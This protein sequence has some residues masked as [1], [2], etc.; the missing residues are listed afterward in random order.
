MK[1]ILLL[2]L[3]LIASANVWAADFITDV[4]VIGGSKSVVND[5]KDTY[6][7]QGW[8]VIDQDLNKGCGSSSDYIYLL[9]KKASNVSLDAGAFITGFYISDASGT[10][11]DN[12]TH[13][14]H[15]YTLVPY[16]GSDYFMGTKGDLNSHCGANSAYIHLYY[17]KDNDE[18]Y[19]STAV[20]AI[21]FND[22]QSGA[23]GV[24][25]GTTGYDLNTGGGGDYIYMHT[26]AGTKGWT[27]SMN[28]AQT[29]CSITGY[30]GT[31]TNKTAITIP[32]YIDGAQV[33]GFTGTVFSGWT[34][35]ETMVFYANTQVSQM[36]S[37][38][39]CSK[40][41]NIKTG[42]VNYKTPSSMTS[43]PASAFVGTAIT[44]VTLTSVTSVG[45]NAFAGSTTLN[46]VVFSK[47]GVT[48]GDGAFS[49][50]VRSGN[51]KCQVTY[52]GVI[53]D[54]SPSKYMYSPSLVVNG[55]SGSSAWSCGWC[56]GGSSS[57][58]NRLYWTL[59]A[60]GQLKIDCADNSWS[61]HPSDQIIIT[62][63][64]DK[65]KVKNLTIEHVYSIAQ[66]EFQSCTNLVT[67]D[68]KSGVTNIGNFAFNSCT[69]LE[70]AYLPSCLTSIGEYAFRS[71]EL[72]T[73]LFFNGTQQQWGN[74][75]KGTGWNNYVSD[76]FTEHWRCTV[77]F[78]ANGHGTAP[79]AQTL[80][81]NYDKATTPTAPTANGC[82]FQGWYTE[83][84]CTNQ[85][86]FNTVV[87]GDMTL[88]A[89]WAMRYTYNS[90]TGELALLWGE[91]N[92]DNKWG[93][94][95]PAEA[96]TSV[97]ATS[98][99][100]FTGDCSQLFS[101][102][103]NCTSMDLDSVNTSNVTNMISMFS[104]CSS[105]TSLNISS[106]NTGNVT[107]MSL[108]FS[109][110]SSLT[111][112]N[113]S[114]WNTSNVT[115]M[116][117]MFRTCSKLTSLDITGWDTGNVE[118]MSYMFNYCTSL[119]SLNLSGWNITRVNFMD[120]MFQDCT[121]LTS[122]DL[123]G[124]NIHSVSN[125]TGMFSLCSSLKS[126]NLSGWVI[127]RWGISYM[128]KDCNQLTTIYTTTSW[129]TGNVD[130][131]SGMFSGCTKLVGGMGTTY[132]ENHT[133]KE[134]ARI[135]RGAEQPGYFTGVFKLI[136]P[137][138]VTTSA[139]P[140][141]TIGDSIYYAAGTAVILTYTGNV[142]EGKVV[143]FAV[144]G[145]AIDGNTFEMPLNDVT[146][147]ATVT[148]PP[149]YTYD[150]ATG[151]LTLL[152]GEFNKDNKWGN[153]VPAT[154]VKSVT[155]TSKVSFTGDC[156]QLFYNFESCESM[157]L[158]HVNTSAMTSTC[159]MFMQCEALTTLNISSWNTGNVTNMG[160]MFYYCSSMKSFDISGW[161]TASVT[162]MESMFSYCDSLTSL[163][164]SSWNTSAV[165]NMEE[166]F[167]YCSSMKSFDIS[168]WNTASVTSMSGM[169]SFCDSLTSLNLSGWNM[170]NVTNLSEMF[171][172]CSSM[173]SINISGW[174]TTN[175][176]NMS[177]MFVRCTGLT[178]LDLSGWDTGNVTNMYEMFRACSNLTTI[179]VGAD[180]STE[181]VTTSGFMFDG[182]TSLVGGMGTTYDMY[183]TNKEYAHID[184]GSANPGYLS[185]KTPRYTYDSTTGVLSLNWGT[186]NK[187]DK[188]GSEVI[189]TDVTSVTATSD[190][191]FTGDCS[192]LFKGFSNCTSM[193]LNHVNTS[194]VI[195]IS[196]MFEN[197]SSLTLLD[198]SN[199]N[200]G[201][202]NIMNSMFKSCTSLNSLDVSN[203]NTS[204][205]YTMYSMFEGC[206]SLVRLDLSGWDTRNGTDMSRMF[207]GC[208]KL[209]TICVGGRWTTQIALNS[210]SMFY[211]C[212]S[213]VGGMGTTYDPSH[214]DKE[215]AHID[216]GPSNPGYFTDANAPVVVPGDV[217]GDG[218][219]D[220][221]DITALIDVIM[222]SITDNP[223]A[224][225]NGDTD[226]DVRDIT[227]L[228][229]IIMNS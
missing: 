87:P 93:N 215:Y 54:W 125:M 219:V 144:N 58:Y 14:G 11:P 31:K 183:H 65:S 38:Q 211:G 189:A 226:I 36:P 97:T 205:V 39:G 176:T 184:G 81:S 78:N 17:T 80:W 111:S 202:V 122:L 192:E 85:W 40:F 161:N 137:E 187:D 214:T 159:E 162:N 145:T 4:M 23:V 96:V 19:S 102:F 95:V 153:D 133:D 218:E 72:L 179:Y 61:N 67:L 113:V 201:N 213:L 56:G 158:N 46:S 25:G 147:T 191:S 63:N 59:D 204:M 86:D 130:Y 126:V 55:G 166:L 92:K 206:S 104:V 37:V 21:S 168:G 22:T 135:D 174:N 47:S 210:N 16:D 143:V 110:C 127:G 129:Y 154:A 107:D 99:V 149:R 194:N 119:T 190:V 15:T 73:D 156:S 33:T 89:K 136:L 224:D 155:A 44:D 171:Y 45:E 41:K 51:S 148:D 105:L 91:F 79:A 185:A 181:K 227:A 76:D 196:G 150:S 118:S 165:T 27:I 193:D 146:I 186:F 223:R 84:A 188:W 108:M 43:I 180:W 222:N 34:N 207:F 169:F 134:Y 62:H 29:Q 69:K 225:V 209:R 70:K 88:Y 124:W 75:T 112:L 217:N 120:F 220:V 199:W 140:V 28:S 172:Y 18:Y 115:N 26:T 221:R 152:W 106:W 13:D 8:T 228:I 212:T 167:F 3:A 208:S 216:G 71:C 195:N 90:E 123:S 57:S 103:R 10:A 52:P 1:K 64:W 139:T 20:N 197:C 182:C 98:Q 116:F 24:N 177:G 101:G 157:D 178:S 30:Q 142:P 117:Q 164:I 200:T 12:V 9:Y 109:G 50:I 203:F 6:T 32:N 94:D 198:L 35:L 60:A 229:D 138:D 132:D 121:K 100:S 68:V 83:A 66:Y 49:Y 160:G 131:S 5:L 114:N 77:T 170:G 173:T 53:G 175:V 42:N 7:S 82:I 151:E 74:V 2:L 48:I 128:F 141:C 163:D